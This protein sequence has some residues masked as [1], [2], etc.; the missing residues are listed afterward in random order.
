MKARGGRD[1][2]KAMDVALL[3]T[4]FVRPEGVLSQFC[5]AGSENASG[6]LR[7]PTLETDGKELQDFN[8]FAER[9]C[10]RWRR[11][12]PIERRDPPGENDVSQARKGLNRALATSRQLQQATL[13]TSLSQPPGQAGIVFQVAASLQQDTI[14]CETQSWR[15]QARCSSMKEAT[16]HQPRCN[17]SGCA[18]ANR[19]PRAARARAVASGTCQRGPG[20]PGQPIRSDLVFY[21]GR[22][23]KRLADIPISRERAHDPHLPAEAEVPQVD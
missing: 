18:T 12:T 17:T 10:R 9:G 22:L 11:S 15:I 6:S 5:Q 8:R 7:R 3:R 16:E 1:Q 23:H 14:I 19:Q 4:F 2:S 13:L 21:R 20:E